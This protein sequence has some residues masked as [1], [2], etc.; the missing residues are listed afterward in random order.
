MERREFLFN[1]SILGSAVLV[2][3]NGFESKS[4]TSVSEEYPDSLYVPP[5][6]NR[7][8]LAYEQTGNQLTTVELKLPPKMCGPAPH[9]HEE[10]DEIVRVLSG[11]L[12][13]MVEDEI[14]QLPEGAWHFRPRKK[15]HGF[16]NA[17]DKPVHFIEI[18]PNQNFDV[19]LKQIWN[20]RDKLRAEGVSLD[21]PEAWAQVDEIQKDWGITM[22]HERRKEIILKHGLKG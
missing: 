21:S 9:I 12:T 6:E 2:G 7:I 10:L 18:S 5:S 11:T 3:C 16:W 15:V 22:F 14:I 17:T 20:L 19:M 13:V 8:K 4:T 1:T